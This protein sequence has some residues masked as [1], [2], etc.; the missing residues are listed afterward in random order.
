MPQR[1]TRGGPGVCTGVRPQVA[2]MMLRSLLTL[3][4][5]PTGSLEI[6]KE[7][8]LF[9][10]CAPSWDLFI[11]LTQDLFSTLARVFIAVLLSFSTL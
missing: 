9:S 1:S 8:V 3:L 10:F 6:F 4:V 5:P 2:P 7:N 11:Y